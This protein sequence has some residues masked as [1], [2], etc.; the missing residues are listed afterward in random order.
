MR[1][2]VRTGLVYCLAPG[3]GERAQG[4]CRGTLRKPRLHHVH[5][6]AYLSLFLDILRLLRQSRQIVFATSVLSQL[7]N[8]DYFFRVVLDI[9]KYVA[10]TSV[11]ETIT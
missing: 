1:G 3:C 11:S 4:S 7:N 8:H 2:V 5:T 10:K 6:F 9:A